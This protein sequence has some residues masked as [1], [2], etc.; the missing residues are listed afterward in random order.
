MEK[1][2][3]YNNVTGDIYYV[4]TIPESKAIRLCAMNSDK[5]MSYVL[6]SEID[7]W[8]DNNRTIELNLSTTPISVNKL[9]EYSPSASELAK[10]K[11]NTLLTASDWTVG[12]D[13]PLSDSKKAEWQTYRQ[14]LRDYDYSSITEDY[15]IVWPT[16]PA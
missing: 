3:L 8:V 5:N 9:P 10:Q 7:G 1:Y 14:T 12:V 11:R 6:E 15:G 16:P 2:V 4:K 13:S